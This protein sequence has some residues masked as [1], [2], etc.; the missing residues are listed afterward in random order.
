MK[1]L[2]AVASLAVLAGCAGW[3][4]LASSP[5]ESDT[6]TDWVCDSQATVHWRFADAAQES[7]DVRLADDQVHRLKLEPS[8]SGALY[9]DDQLAFHLKGEEGL[10]Y[11]VATNDLIGRGCKAKQ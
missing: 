4:P 10:V 3:N 5:A 1:G 8:G 6:W 9:S 11:W 2:I 7:V